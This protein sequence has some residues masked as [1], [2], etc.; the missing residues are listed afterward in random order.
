MEANSYHKVKSIE[1]HRK[2]HF[3]AKFHEA[4]GFI[5]TVGQTSSIDNNLTNILLKI[6]QILKEF[7]SNNN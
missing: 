2:L 3:F 5:V 4:T 6:I 7:I 1:I